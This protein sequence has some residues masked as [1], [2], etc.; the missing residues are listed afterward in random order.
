MQTSSDENKLEKVIKTYWWTV[1]IIVA[2]LVLYAIP[3]KWGLPNRDDYRGCVSE[4][5]A[6]V[7]GVI[8]GASKEPDNSTKISA[9]FDNVDELKGR[10][11]VFYLD[12]Y[13]TSY[14][15]GNKIFMNVNSDGDP[16]VL[17]IE[18]DTKLLWNLLKRAFGGEPAYS[19]KVDLKT[20]KEVD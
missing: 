5:N 16:I 13:K 20:L 4:K 8:T 2:V 18:S 11:I 15:V 3:A 1:P 19:A 6:C 10:E 14:G 12:K 17:F 7:Y 9:G